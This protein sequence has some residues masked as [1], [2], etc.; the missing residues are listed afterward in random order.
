MSA[1]HIC[2]SPQGVI[3]E[4]EDARRGCPAPPSRWPALAALVVATACSGQ[5]STG[6]RQGPTA[7]E[8]ATAP[9]VT[10]EVLDWG[11]T[12]RPLVFLAGGGHTAHQFHDFAPRL[13]EDFWGSPAA[14]P[15]R[16][17]LR[18]R[19]LCVIRWTTSSPFWTPS[20][21]TQRC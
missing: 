4:A 13:A 10:L 18:H 3:P 16:P 17:L 5:P 21:S 15:V 20:P 7:L 12:G 14:G 19:S 11:G 8:V 1:H 6:E 2:S 9:G